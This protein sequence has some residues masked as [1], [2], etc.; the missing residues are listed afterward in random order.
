M[1]SIQDL[2]NYS[3]TTL[4]Y[5][6]ERS[7]SIT[8]SVEPPINHVVELANATPHTA[9]VGTDITEIINYDQVS[10]VYTINLAPYGSNITA[11][12]ANIPSTVA[13]SNPSSGRYVFSNIA[14]VSD[15][16][17]VKSPTLTPT[18]GFTGNW[19]YTGN[20]SYTIANV[21]NS[22]S[23]TN[24][25]T[26]SLSDY[27]LTA[28]AASSYD[29]NTPKTI[30]QYPQI[31]DPASNANGTFNITIS[32]NNI[33]SISTMSSTGSAQSVFDYANKRLSITGNRAQVND[34][35]ASIT[36]Q[37]GLDFLGNFSMTYTL[38]NP[39]G[40]VITKNQLYT[41]GSSAIVSHINDTFT[42]TK[43]QG[44]QSIFSANTPQIVEYIT[45]AYYDLYLS[46]TAG[47]FGTSD[48][49]KTSN[50][51]I[52]G[53]SS[54][55]NSAISG[56]KFWPLKDYANAQTFNLQL[57]RNSALALSADID[58]D[59]LDTGRTETLTFTSGQYWTPT[60]DQLYYSNNAT[61][62]VVGAGAGSQINGGGGGGGRVT[63]TTANLA[64]VTYTVI[65]GAG[66]ASSQ[67]AGQY[68]TNGQS[69]RIG[70]T[71]IGNIS[72]S[73]GNGTNGY[74]GGSSTNAGGTGV[75]GG[76]GGGGGA[77]A[78]GS[79]GVGAPTYRGG[80]GGNG[81]T[82]FNGSTYGGGGGGAGGNSP[83][84]SGGTGGGGA[85]AYST[86]YAQSGSTNSGGGAGADMYGYS[87]SGGSGIVIVRINY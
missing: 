24:Y 51:H 50:Y 66:G 76:A 44:S 69:S 57:N 75:S 8:F 84:S 25:V 14:R 71:S 28:I 7:P 80:K 13:S 4:T 21:A 27:Y 52:T 46:T 23:W 11:T 68:S 31:N 55:I 10:V 39:V 40:T 74:N 30:D 33:S 18:G 22:R 81:V 54:T 73:G 20:I 47:Y 82:A 65:V 67:H 5:T 87:T 53:N 56:I 35:L 2:N 17:A 15:W 62:L 59:G 42:F 78:A 43:N 48:A 29:R 3:G 79:N 64:N 77:G 9:V 12:W 72:A 85:G 58:M 38:T 70:A 26:S 6:D 32:T 61:F 63:E 37:P 86:G 1:H 41:L 45:G 49:D 60:A 34:N 83:A 16:E 36:F 19:Q